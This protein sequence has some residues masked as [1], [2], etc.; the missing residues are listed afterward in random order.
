LLLKMYRYPSNLFI[1]SIAFDF[2][3]HYKLRHRDGGRCGCCGW[4]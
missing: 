3:V 2:L 4:F 1:V